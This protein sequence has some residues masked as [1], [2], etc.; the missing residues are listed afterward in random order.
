MFYPAAPA[1][2]PGEGGGG[3]REPLEEES[4]QSEGAFSSWREALQAGVT[5]REGGE[6]GASDRPSVTL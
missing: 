6:G 4:G 1:D 5:A 2:K 3:V